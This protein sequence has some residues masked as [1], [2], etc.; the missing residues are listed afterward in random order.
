MLRDFHS[1]PSPPY[2]HLGTPGCLL[3]YL[4]FLF[5]YLFYFFWGGTLSRLV[6]L[7]REFLLSQINLEYNLVDLFILIYD[8][9]VFEM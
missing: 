4:V 9:S 3:F 8:S 5:I 7:F 1:L 6:Y 2:Y